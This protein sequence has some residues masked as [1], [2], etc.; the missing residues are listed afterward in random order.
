MARRS[1]PRTI[2]GFRVG[3]RRN[4]RSEPNSHGAPLRNQEKTA[5]RSFIGRLWR[6]GWFLSL[7]PAPPA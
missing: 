5:C 7:R 2:L 6:P 3:L 4:V 1:T